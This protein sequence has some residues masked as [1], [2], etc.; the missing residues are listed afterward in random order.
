MKKIIIL[1]LVFLFVGLG[2]QPAIAPISLGH[3]IKV[4]DVNDQFLES[5]ENFGFGY[6]LYDPENQYDP[7]PVIFDLDEP[8][9]VVN[10]A[11]DNNTIT[12]GCYD[13]YSHT[14]YVCDDSG[15]IWTIEIGSGDMTLIGGSYG[16]ISALAYNPQTQKMYGAY[17]SYL[18]EI[19][20]QSGEKLWMWDINE[21]FLGPILGMSTN[22]LDSLYIVDSF[23][24]LCRIDLDTLEVTFIGNLLIGITGNADLEFDF[25][26]G[27]LYLSTYTTQGELYKV[28]IW[29]GQATLIGG[30]EEG[31][32][33][34]GFIIPGYLPNQPPEAPMV[35]WSPKYPEPFEI[36]T[37]TFNSV[38]PDGDDVRFLIDWGDGNTDITVW[39]GSGINKT[40][41]HI[42]G[43]KG[44][45]YINVTAQDGNGAMSD[46]TTVK[47]IVGKSKTVNVE[48][49][50]PDSNYKD[51]WNCRINHLEGIDGSALLFPGY[52]LSWNHPIGVYVKRAFGVLINNCKDLW[53][54][55]LVIKNDYYHKNWT[56]AFVFSFTGYFYNYYNSPRW[57]LFDIDGTVKFIRIY[58]T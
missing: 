41:S 51:Y 47:I 14:W 22:G 45:Y 38:D 23:D 27:E 18:Y 15:N 26:A 36:Y 53:P 35:W 5:Y 13:Y 55:Y 33:I 30:F 58:T 12:G 1:G 24:N 17:Q 28:N 48:D 54:Y 25:I 10:L 9:I 39:V 8:E 50:L 16:S 21:Y 42:A 34:S 31:A 44:T 2:F 40:I 19:D 57:K 46:V 29:D 7:G 49:K 20:M 6:R 52:F 37:L 32:R 3:D 56:K 11:Y 43:P 4:L